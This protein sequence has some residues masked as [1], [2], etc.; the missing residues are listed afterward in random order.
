MELLSDRSN[1]QTSS[2]ERVDLR[3]TTLIPTLDPARGRNKVLL[4]VRGMGSLM[5]GEGID[6]LPT[7]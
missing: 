7:L 1:R 6:A 5:P 3:V 2:A 4:Q